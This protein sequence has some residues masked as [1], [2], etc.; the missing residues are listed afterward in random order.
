MERASW[1]VVMIEH[2]N[3][4]GGFTYL[5]RSIVDALEHLAERA[6]ADALLLGEDEF[7]I[8]FLWEKRERY[9]D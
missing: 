1:Q 8:D 3:D 4:D 6:L 9:L 5:L 7:R 2:G